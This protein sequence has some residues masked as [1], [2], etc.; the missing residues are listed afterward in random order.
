MSNLGGRTIRKKV[1][2]G[3]MGRRV[4]WVCLI[5]EEEEEK[6]VAYKFPIEIRIGRRGGGEK[7]SGDGENVR[8]AEEEARTFAL[9]RKKKF[10]SQQNRIFRGCMVL[11]LSIQFYFFS[12]GKR[13]RQ[14]LFFAGLKM[15]RRK[16]NEKNRI[17]EQ[18]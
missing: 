18:K 5:A 17:E 8:F 13:S 15:A 3:W 11:F 2:V 4:R 6:D 10:F 7:I 12:A 1:L 16:R 14:N 9:G